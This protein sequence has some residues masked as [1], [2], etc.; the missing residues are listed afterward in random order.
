MKLRIDPTSIL[1][2][3]AVRTPVA[4]D[5]PGRFHVTPVIRVCPARRGGNPLVAARVS[6]QPSNLANG[7]EH[8]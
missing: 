1:E 3:A 8:N 2:R 7:Y 4:A 5:P 6:P